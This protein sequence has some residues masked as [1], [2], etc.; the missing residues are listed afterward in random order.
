MNDTQLSKDSLNERKLM[1]EPDTT[2][3]ADIRLIQPNVTVQ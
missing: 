1:K 3:R 2:V